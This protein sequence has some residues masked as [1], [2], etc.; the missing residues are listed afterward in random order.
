MGKLDKNE[1]DAIRSLTDSE[2]F[3]LF[4]QIAEIQMKNLNEARGNLESLSNSPNLIKIINFLANTKESD[5]LNA[6]RLEVSREFWKREYK[7]R[8]GK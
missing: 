1:I 7:K 5:R 2:L 3:K 8:R 6:I 4:S